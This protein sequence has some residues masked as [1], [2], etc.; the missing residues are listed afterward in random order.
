MTDIADNLERELTAVGDD[1]DNFAGHSTSLVSTI[2]AKVV[3]PAKAWNR[4][5]FADSSGAVFALF[6]VYLGWLV[7]YWLVSLWPDLNWF[8]G[9]NSVD[10][11]P[12]YGSTN[13][14]IFRWVD[15]ETWFGPVWIVAMVA[16]IGL[17]TGRMVRLSG[18]YLG[19]AVMSIINENNIIWNAG[20]GL[21]RILCMIF[22]I[23]CF[24]MPV[25]ALHT[26]LFGNRT[27]DG[28]RSWPTVPAWTMRLVQLQLTVIYANTVIEKIPGAP[29]REGLASAMALKLDT[30]D[31]VWV[32][33]FVT[34]NLIIVNLFTWATL[35]LEIALPVILWNLR[36]RKV[37]IVAGLAM[38]FL[39]D[40]GLF[41]GAFSWAMY[42]CYIAFFPPA[43]AEGLISW[44]GDRIDRA[45]FGSHEEPDTHTA[46]AG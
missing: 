35:G 1:H 32:P 39:F 30:M 40:L 20:D 33:E 19:I 2:W 5:F 29:W 27:T 12:W 4:F 25:T 24:V 34:E 36:T 18:I 9:D 46:S 11:I 3:S 42:A 22:A 31:R 45:R 6:R 26:P 28:G 10:P 41:V 23:S 15:S 21:I 7:F 43:W 17:M 8:F 14:G 13:W 44:V 16:S 38:H 37:A